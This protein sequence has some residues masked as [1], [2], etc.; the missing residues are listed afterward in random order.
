MQAMAVTMLTFALSLAIATFVE[1]D[2]DTNT[3]KALIYQAQWFEF[4]LLYLVSIL[5]YNMTKFKMYKKPLSMKFMFHSAFII[6]LV[7]LV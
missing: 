6:I 1:N 7:V 4:L 3:A 2:Y 5:M